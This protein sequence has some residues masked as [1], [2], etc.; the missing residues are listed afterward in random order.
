MKMLFLTLFCPLQV[1]H[2][3]P[4]NQADSFATLKKYQDEVP[5]CHSDHAAASK[6]LEGVK[7]PS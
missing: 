7:V 6:K 5:L 3:I 4:S 1:F 2:C